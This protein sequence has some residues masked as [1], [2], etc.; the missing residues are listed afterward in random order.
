MQ[1]RDK[2]PSR[3]LDKD[4]LDDLIERV[5]KEYGW[6]N[7]NQGFCELLK[8]LASCYQHRKDD[9]KKKLKAYI[10]EIIDAVD[11]DEPDSAG[12][13][14]LVSVGLWGVPLEIYQQ[15]LDKASNVN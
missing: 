2:P 15:L 3:N 14:P 6:S 1:T 12:H 5:N 4:W 13:F 8:D 10:D 9:D 7:R 11:V